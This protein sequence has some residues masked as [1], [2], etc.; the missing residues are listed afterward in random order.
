MQTNRQFS[1]NK[2]I[3]NQQ[4]AIGSQLPIAIGTA[5]GKQQSEILQLKSHNLQLTTEI[6]N[7][8]SYLPAGSRSGVEE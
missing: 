5:I 1:L 8:K 2:K 6:E 7:I 3:F 4:K